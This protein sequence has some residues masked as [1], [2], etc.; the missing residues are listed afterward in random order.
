MKYLT[1]ALAVAAFAATPLNAASVIENGDF[2]SDLPFSGTISGWTQV[3]ADGASIQLVNGLLFGPCCA[4]VGSPAALANQFA[5]FGSG[6]SSVDGVSLEQNFVTSNGEFTLSFDVGAI[7]NPGLLQFFTF[8]VTDTLTSDVLFAGASAPQ[9]ANS[10]FDT[11]FQTY[12]YG[13]NLGGSGN[14]NLAFSPVGNTAGADPFLDN[15]SLI[16]AV[17]EP[18]TWAMLMIGFAAVGGMMRSR[19]SKVARLRVKYS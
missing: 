7:G 1:S 18:H 16:L 14:Y 3:E 10:N 11:T 15:I 17:P 12:T 9:M 4:A 8:S 19:K 5:T 6:D 2:E 13:F